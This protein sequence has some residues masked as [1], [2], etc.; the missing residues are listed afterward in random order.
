M[1]STRNFP[2]IAGA[3]SGL[4]ALAPHDLWRSIEILRMTSSTNPASERTPA[5][6]NRFRRT[7]RGWCSDSTFALLNDQV[8]TSLDSFSDINVESPRADRCSRWQMAQEILH[9]LP[10]PS[11]VPVVSE[12]PGRVWCTFQVPMNGL[13]YPTQ[14]SIRERKRFRG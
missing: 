11:A 9:H 7:C 14:S 6:G 4:R 12:M 2:N 3:L 13:C 5:L 8:I 1:S 10:T